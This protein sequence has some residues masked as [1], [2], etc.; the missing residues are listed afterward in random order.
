MRP[1]RQQLAMAEPMMFNVSNEVFVDLRFA[2]DLYRGEPDAVAAW[3]AIGQYNGFFAEHTEYYRGARSVATLAIVLDN[4]S[5]GQATMNGLAGRNVLYNV[6]YEHELTPEKLKPYAAV[7]LLAADTVRDRALAALETVRDGGRK[8]VRRRRRPPRRTRRARPRQRPAWFGQ[9][10]GQGETTYWQKTPPIDEL[11][12]ALLAADR[13]PPVRIEAPKG[14]LYNVTRQAQKGR[15][16]VHL[17]NYLPHAGG[18][19][20][21]DGGRQARA[22]RVA[23]ARRHAR[24]APHRAEHGDRHRDRAPAAEDLLG[25]GARPGS[26]M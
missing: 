16:M 25:A 15:L 24:S 17:L 8:A 3:K 5:E 22:G 20:R 19:G 21:G 18:E 7:A 1:E 26:L 4:R 10:L 14:V 6:L 23:H 11:A 13:P 12:K 9:K 2:H